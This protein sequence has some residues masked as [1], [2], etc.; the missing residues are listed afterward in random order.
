MRLFQAKWRYVMFTNR[1]LYTLNSEAYEDGTT[2]KQDSLIANNIDIDFLSHLIF[3]P[4]FLF[5]SYEMFDVSKLKNDNQKRRQGIVKE[6]KQK[7][8]KIIIG[9]KEGNKASQYKFNES[10]IALETTMWTVLQI[11]HGCQLVN[12][13]ELAQEFNS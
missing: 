6:L 2:L 10:D 5:D 4:K 8:C 7:R 1:R 9:F 12:M 13:S 11:I 3:I